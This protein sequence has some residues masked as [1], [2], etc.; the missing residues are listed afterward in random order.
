MIVVVVSDGVESERK[1][2]PQA[3]SGSLWHAKRAWGFPNSSILRKIIA[4][5]SS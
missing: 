4:G 3:E 5:K 1:V 2:R